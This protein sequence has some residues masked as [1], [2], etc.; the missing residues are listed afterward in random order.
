MK[1]AR[2]FEGIVSAKSSSELSQQKILS[3][4]SWNAGPK[5]GEVTN[6]MVASFHVILVQEAE[7]HHHEI[8]TNAERQFH[9]YQGV[10]CDKSMFEHEGVKIQEEIPGTSKQDS[11]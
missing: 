11:V 7:T 2:P 1:D 3:I 8:M 9:I 5:R 4:L 6:R 10:L